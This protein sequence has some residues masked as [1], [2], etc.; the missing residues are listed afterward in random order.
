MRSV[1]LFIAFVLFSCNNKQEKVQEQKDSVTATEVNNPPEKI[2]PAEPVIVDTGQTWFSVNITRNDTSFIAYE[3]T[4][5]MLLTAGNFATLQL[6]RS[7]NIM[8]VSDI[9]TFYIYGLSLG[10][11]PVLKNAGKTGEVSMIMSPVK[12]GA[13]G[14]PIIPDKGSFTLTKKDSTTISGNYEGEVID[15]QD[16]FRF[17]GAF[18]NV[19]FQN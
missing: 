19:K 5:P 13:Y 3:G 7:K 16:V 8:G 11:T 12:D 2:I 17:K 10:K 4:W 15:K 1:F 9:L 18:L 14:L 6:S